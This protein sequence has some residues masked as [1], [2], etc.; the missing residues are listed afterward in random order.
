MKPS[1]LALLV[2]SY[3]CAP[4][5]YIPNMQNITS[6]KEEIELKVIIAKA[7]LGIYLHLL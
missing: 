3:S 7:D 5:M 4:E 2:F 6:F 1:L